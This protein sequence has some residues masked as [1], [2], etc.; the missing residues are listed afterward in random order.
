V[1]GWWIL[2]TKFTS[3]ND[4]FLM[5]APAERA[6][7]LPLVLL[8]PY[9]YSVHTTQ[10][11]ITV[12]FLTVFAAFFMSPVHIIII[13]IIIIILIRASTTALPPIGNVGQYTDLHAC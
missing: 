3:G 6:D 8:Y 12:T 5:Y 2:H 9:I 4:H 11:S 7:K 10:H 1:H 13:I